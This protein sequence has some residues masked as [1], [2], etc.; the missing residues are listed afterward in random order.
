MLLEK[1][2]SNRSVSLKTCLTTSPGA[3]VAAADPVWSQ[4]FVVLLHHHHDRNNQINIKLALVKLQL[5]GS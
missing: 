1:Q 3:A 4:A 2:H 5:A